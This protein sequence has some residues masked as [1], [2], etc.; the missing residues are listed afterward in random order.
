MPRCNNCGRPHGWF[1]DRCLLSVLLGLAIGG[2]NL[3]IPEARSMIDTTNV[4]ALWDDMGPI[5]DNL[6]AGHYQYPKDEE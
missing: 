4:D 1:R 6:A 5:I 2:D 3:T